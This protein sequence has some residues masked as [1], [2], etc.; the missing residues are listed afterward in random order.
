MTSEDNNRYICSRYRKAKWSPLA[1]W[2]VTK[3]CNASLDLVCC[4]DAKNSDD[5]YAYLG[6]ESDEQFTKNTSR[7]KEKGK[8]PL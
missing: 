3:N 6:S 7:S 5:Y 2:V 1:D 4:D 8:I